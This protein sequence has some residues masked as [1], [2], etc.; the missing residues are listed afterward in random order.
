MK[1]KRTLTYWGAALALAVFGLVV[2]QVH[3]DESKGEEKVT[4]PE[5][6]MSAFHK[7][8]PEAKILDV[9]RETK[10]GKLY[11]EIES[12]DKSV[13][14]DLLYSADGSVFEMEEAISVKELPAKVSDGLKASF[15]SGKIERAERITRGKTVEYEVLVE[16]KEKRTE[17]LLDA[18]GVVKSHASAA[19]E[20]EDSSHNS[21]NEADED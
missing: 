9:S 3:A 8:Y 21:G 15:P 14:R 7:A 17:V 18:N 4:A 5:A 10:E 20:D 2:A 13:R 19:D 16:N 11:Y 1:N 6:V 12:K